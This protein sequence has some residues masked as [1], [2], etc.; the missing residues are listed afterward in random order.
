MNEDISIKVEHVSKKYSKSLKKSML[1]GVEDI[2]R[3]LIG[4]SSR[5]NRL[6]K[7]E[8]WAVDDVSFEVRKGET[9]GI[10]GPNGAGKT[11]LLK[12]LNGIFWP[13][14]GKIAVRGRIGALIEVGAGFHPLFTGRENVYINGAI[15]GM[16]K[17]EIDRK[18]DSIVEFAGIGDFI[19][20]P[21][22]FYSSGMFVRLGFA[23]AVHSEPDILLVDE[24][25]AVGDYMFQDKCI[26][27]LNQFRTEG[28]TMIIV[29]HN[30]IRIEK[31][32]TMAVLQYKG[33][34]ISIGNPEEVLNVYYH[35]VKEKEISEQILKVPKSFQNSRKKARGARILD[36]SVYDNKGHD[37]RVFDAGENMVVK[38]TIESSIKIENALLYC[39][40]Y[41]EDGLEI[42]G[43]NP[44]RSGL[45]VDLEKDSRAVWELTYQSLNILDGTYYLNVGLQN[46]WFSPVF[47]DR[48]DN[49]FRFVI[50]SNLSQGGGIPLIPH[51]WIRID[52][53]KNISSVN[54]K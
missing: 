22:K 53:Q 18:F 41:R 21:V 13:D 45:K 28:K 29:S 2:G 47:L 23:V 25:L 11:T 19:D 46:D 4:L 44:G 38:I 16:N 52:N 34:V 17:Q 48:K 26:A 40:I 42:H 3:N 43:T 15:L 12:M 27:K 35:E 33:K 50:A 1:Y 32:C 10:I 24:V 14:K 49:I 31:L 9:L 6:R 36:V 39:R 8:F 37:K 51:Q 7:K 20:V 54:L 30:R 5:S